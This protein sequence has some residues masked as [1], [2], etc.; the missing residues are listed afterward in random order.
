MY[1]VNDY[2]LLTVKAGHG[3]KRQVMIIILRD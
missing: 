2:F 1:N 3:N